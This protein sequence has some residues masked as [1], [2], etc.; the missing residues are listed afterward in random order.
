MSIRSRFIQ[1]VDLTPPIDPLTQTTHT[2]TH[3]KS[4]Q[5]ELMSICQ[6]VSFDPKPPIDPPMG[7]SVS[8][9]HGLNYPVNIFKI[10]RFDLTPPINPPNHPP[11]HQ[12]THP[13]MGGEFFTVSLQTE[14][15]YLDKLDPILNSGGPPPWGVADGWMGWG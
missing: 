6:D 12:T 2:P 3:Y 9:N 11:T 14:L 7:G 15:K 4:L 8:T 5:T 10:F 1:L 13:P